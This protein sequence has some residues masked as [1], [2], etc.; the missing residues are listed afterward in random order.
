METILD[1]IASDR[2]KYNCNVRTLGEC[3]IVSP[4]RHH[5]FIRDGQR[6]LLTGDMG[7]LEAWEAK[8]GHKPS[9]ERAGAHEKIFHD[10]SWTRVGIVTAGGLCPGL[11]N[12]IKG[13]V[14]ILSADYG[15]RNI[16]GIRYGYAGLNP[17]CGYAPIPLDVDSVDTM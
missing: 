17:E 11:N 7:V 13:L 2:K 1:K 10:P 3:K 14:E 15:I 9:F 12:V 6:V 16:F 5:D 8:L 4:V